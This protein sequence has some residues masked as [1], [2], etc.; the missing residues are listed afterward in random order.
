MKIKKILLLAALLTVAASAWTTEILANRPIKTN[1]YKK[2]SIVLFVNQ[3]GELDSTVDTYLLISNSNSYEPIKLTTIPHEGGAPIIESVFTDD[4]DRNGKLDLIILAKW[5]VNHT[6][7]GTDGYYY[8]AYV[9]DGN[10]S[11]NP[12]KFPRLEGVE[13]KIGSG[14]DGIREGERVVFKYKNAEA[15]RKLL[16]Q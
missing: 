4:A 6:G 7:A 15:I 12:L 3:G 13:S 16:H 11:G 5:R 9:F 1:F 2:N 10:A 14:L 8:Q